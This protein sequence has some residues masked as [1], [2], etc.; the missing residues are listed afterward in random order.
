[1]SDLYNQL[2]REVKMAKTGPLPQGPLHTAHGKIC[3][4][5]NLGAITKEEFLDLEHRCV[6]EGINNPKYFDR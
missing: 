2:L 5:F 4:A 6:A 3:M 1:M